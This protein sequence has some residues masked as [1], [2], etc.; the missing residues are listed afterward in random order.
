[1]TTR[2]EGDIDNKEDA[3]KIA[4]DPEARELGDAYAP[5]GTRLCRTSLYLGRL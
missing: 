4:N 5:L 1:M 3:L 2:L